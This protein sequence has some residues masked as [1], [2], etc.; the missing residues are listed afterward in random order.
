[1]VEQLDGIYDQPELAGDFKHFCFFSLSIWDGWFVIELI[2]WDCLWAYDKP[3]NH[4]VLLWGHCS[5]RT[6]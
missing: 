4:H 5:F 2:F 1:M 3:E 6:H